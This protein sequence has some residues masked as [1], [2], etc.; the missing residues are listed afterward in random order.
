MAQLVEALRHK[1]EGC[2]F[3]SQQGHC[4][5]PLIQYVRLHYGPVVTQRLKEISTKVVPWG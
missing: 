1:P 3:G 2:G 4:D 5:F